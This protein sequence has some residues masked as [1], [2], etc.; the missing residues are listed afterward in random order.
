M[1]SSSTRLANQESG[2]RLWKAW[3]FHLQT[4][5]V[6]SICT[7]YTLQEFRCKSTGFSNRLLRS[8]TSSISAF[9]VALPAGGVQ[10]IIGNRIARTWTRTRAAL[11]GPVPQVR[12]TYLLRWKKNHSTPYRESRVILLFWNRGSNTTEHDAGW[13]RTFFLWRTAKKSQ[14]DVTIH[15]DIS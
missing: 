5:S 9:W 6:G 3:S 8:S 14:K 7:W 12:S 4:C 11:Q 10:P 1:N 15:E 13:F 2:C